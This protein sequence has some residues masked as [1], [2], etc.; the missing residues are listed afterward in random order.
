MKYKRLRNVRQL[1]SGV[2]VAELDIEYKRFLFFT[3]EETVMV[4]LTA[5][6]VY[7][8]SLPDGKPL[9][10]SIYRLYNAY[11]VIQELQQST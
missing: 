8:R 5:D 1:P 10:D 2:K 11:T 4:Y 3:Y 9:H 7:W 6:S